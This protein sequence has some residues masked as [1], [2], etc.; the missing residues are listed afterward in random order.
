MF[1]LSLG[2]FFGLFFGEDL[3]DSG[4]G[5]KLSQIADPFATRAVQKIR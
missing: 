3:L 5:A 2:D 1:Q 4:N